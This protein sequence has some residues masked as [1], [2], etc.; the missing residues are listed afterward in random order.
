MKELRDILAPVIQ[1]IFQVSLDSGK[2][3]SDWNNANVCPIFKKG[4]KCEPANYRPISL[5][6]VLCK[7]LEHIVASNVVGHLDTNDILYDLQHG[8]RSKRSCETQLVMLLEDLL[9]NTTEG[10]QTD[11]ILLDF[12]KAFDKVNHAKLLY[13]LHQY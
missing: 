12:S 7:L 10:K 3:P 1:V 4:E 13:K 9:R 8:F 5:T 6:C 11:L 2:V